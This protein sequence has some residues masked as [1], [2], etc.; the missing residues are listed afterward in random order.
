MES[1][2]LLSRQRAEMLLEQEVGVADDD[3]EGGA[4][5]VGNGC[6]KV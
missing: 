2:T 3:I 1:L 6:E 4:Q 5:F